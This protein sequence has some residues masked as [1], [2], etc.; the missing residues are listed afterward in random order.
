MEL[1]AGIWG[2]SQ[3]F[4]MYAPALMDPPAGS[5]LIE[6]WEFF[7]GV[8]GRLGLEP[9]IYYPETLTSTRRVPRAPIDLDMETK[10]TTDGLYA[11]IT[12][13][14]RISLDEVK[15]H[16]N[17][18]VFPEQIRA[19]PRDA[20]CTARL[21]VGNPEMMTELAEV[22]REP[23][24]DSDEYPYRLICRRA[25][26]MYN[27]TGADL[28]ML[29]RKGGTGN[30][31]YMHPQDLAGLGLAP[32][33][34]AELSSRHGAVRAIVQPDDSL[35]PGLVSM[36]HAFGDLPRERA[37]FRLVGSSASQ[38]TSVEDDFDRYSGIPRMSALPLK[39]V[40]V[41]ARARREEVSQ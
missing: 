2:M 15:R 33:D 24:Q 17:G 23:M 20:E 28:P 37:D 14:S 11:L 26:H 35:R 30:P 10:P 9:K 19:E 41:D 1:Y 8:A 39:V 32:G 22:V 38:L 12:R 3:P 5:D 40:P 25:A 4:G 36:T 27:S 6:E 16:P 21:D 7:Y 13:G 29:I 18:M 31:A 34:V